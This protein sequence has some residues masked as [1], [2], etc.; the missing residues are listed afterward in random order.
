MNRGYFSQLMS[1]DGPCTSE[2]SV[3]RYKCLTKY[4]IFLQPQAFCDAQYAPNSFSVGRGSA[5]VP[6]GELTTLVGSSPPYG[7][8]ISAPLEPRPEF[9]F[10]KVGN[11]NRDAGFYTILN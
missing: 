6:L 4:L 8:S 7:V 10:L 9:H 5:P 2:S 11:P 1:S 3:S